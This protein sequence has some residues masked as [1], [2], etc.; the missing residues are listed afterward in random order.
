MPFKEMQKS[1]TSEKNAAEVTKRKTKQQLNAHK[2]N[3][4]G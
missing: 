2:N 4:S 1:G 3:R